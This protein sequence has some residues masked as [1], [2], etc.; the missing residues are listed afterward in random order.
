MKKKWGGQCWFYD[1]SIP[2]R[3]FDSIFLKK[4]SLNKIKDPITRFLNKDVYKEYCKHGIP[5]KLNILL[6]GPPG[7]GKTSIIHSIASEYDANICIL[8]IN[9]E[10]K[11]ETLIDAISQVNEGAK[12]SILVLEDIDC[13]FFDRKKCLLNIYQRKMG[14]KANNSLKSWVKFVKRVQKEEGG[15]YKEAMM[16]AKARKDKGANWMIGGSGS[17]SGPSASGASSTIVAGAHAA[18]SGPTGVS[19]QQTGSSNVLAQGAAAIGSALS[20]AASSGAQVP[21]GTNGGSAPQGQPSGMS[22]P[23][24]PKMGGGK[25]NK[26]TSKKQKGG[27]RKTR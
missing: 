15:S 5:Y 10:L 11:E 4:D 12:R 23:P 27:R 14:R 2:K 9:S 6:H 25:K 20:G 8:N 13:I 3:C 26:K 22:G 1:S 19:S 24:P 18:G 17:A 7:T 16:S 21:A